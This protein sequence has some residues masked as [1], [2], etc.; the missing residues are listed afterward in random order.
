VQPNAEVV[1]VV[2][3]NYLQILGAARALGGYVSP[4]YLVPQQGRWALDLD[5]LRRA[6]TSRTALVAV[7]NPTG[8]VLTEGEIGAIRDNAARVGAWILADEVYR[9]AEWDGEAGPSLWGQCDR[10]LVTSGLSKAYGLPGLRVGWIVASSTKIAE[11]WSYKDYTSISPNPVADRLARQA[12]S[13]ERLGQI[14]ERT[15]GILRSQHPL[16]SAWLARHTD[17]FEAFPPRAGA[18]VFPRRRFEMNSTAFV[19]QLRDEKNVL[20]VPRE[21]FGLDRFLRI[22][23]GI[24]RELLEAGLELVSEFLSS[25]TTFAP[26]A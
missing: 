1:V 23:V 9:G 15:K 14:V 4:V 13:P 24:E 10:V 5:Q 7:N 6:I 17:F 8:A 12:L 26:A 20:L 2:L 16:V 18:I 19:E 11:L 3:P 21:H 25:S 22:G